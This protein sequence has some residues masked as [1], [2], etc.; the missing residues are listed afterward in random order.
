MQAAGV[1]I[2]RGVLG[3]VGGQWFHLASRDHV[4]HMHANAAALLGTQ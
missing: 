3:V 2:F 4:A 1:G